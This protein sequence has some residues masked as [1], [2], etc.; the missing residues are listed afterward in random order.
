[1]HTWILTS[2]HLQMCLRF[3]CPAVKHKSVVHNGVEYNQLKCDNRTNSTQMIV[4][5]CGQAQPIRNY[6]QYCFFMAF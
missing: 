5:F 2:T 1:M 6:V 3:E 4:V